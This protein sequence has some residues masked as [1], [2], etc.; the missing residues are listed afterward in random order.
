MKIILITENL[1]ETWKPDEIDTFLGGSQEC[2]VSFAEALVNNGY[3]V[4]VQTLTDENCANKDVILCER[5]GVK[6]EL[7]TVERFTPDSTLIVFKTQL[8]FNHPKSIYWSSDIESQPPGYEKYVCLTEFHK[9]KC[10]WEN[11]L[12]I[13]HG[14]DFKSLDS[15]WVERDEDAMLYSS[16]PDRGL[17]ILIQNW[18]RIKEHF[19]KLK[20]YVTY[21]MKLFE[22]FSKRKI[23]ISNL[24][25]THDIYYL[26]EIPKNEIESLYWKC[27]YWCLPLNNPNSELFC[28]NAVKA[29]YCGCIPVVIWNGAL[30]DT[31]R[32]YIPFEKFIQG[33]TELREGNQNHLPHSWDEV[34]KTYWEPILKGGIP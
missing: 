29:Q 8:S 16:S 7:N 2:V 26:G 21:G 12:V 19:P 5:N 30:R 1:P 13:P 20:L 4:E 10:G 17:A 28:L 32:S 9:L 3:S 24:N 18:L 15:N 27:K 22:M 31:V 14:I 23:D 6:Y 34:V 25:E 11:S 33:E